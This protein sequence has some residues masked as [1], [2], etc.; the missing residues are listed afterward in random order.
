MPKLTPFFPSADLAGHVSK[1]QRS[2]AEVRQRTVSPPPMDAVGVQ[3]MEGVADRAEV[4]ARL[5][6]PALT[7]VHLEAA[8][9][10]HRPDRLVP[11]LHNRPRPRVAVLCEEEPE[12][13]LLEERFDRRLVAEM[14]PAFPKRSDPPPT[15]VV[16]QVGAATVQE[17]QVGSGLAENPRQVPDFRA[18]LSSAVR[19]APQSQAVRNCRP[20]RMP[21][22]SLTKLHR[23]HL[24]GYS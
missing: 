17:L 16:A 10:D 3:C 11:D 12:F 19:C 9:I 18:S 20:V 7:E 8:G 4:H 5:P 21:G 6:C 13:D 1:L 14:R 2:Q 23:S 15:A 22:G 24:R